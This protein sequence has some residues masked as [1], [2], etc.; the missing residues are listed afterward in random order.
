M[1]PNNMARAQFPSQE[2]SAPVAS[3]ADESILAGFPVVGTVED[4]ANA[5]Q[6]KPSAVR[7]LCRTNQLRAMKCGNLWR[8]PRTWLI[9]FMEKGGNHA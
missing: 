9:D 5:L 1:M 2:E 4:V 3:C 7:S 6:L 8:I